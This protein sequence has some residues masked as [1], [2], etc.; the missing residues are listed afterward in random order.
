[1][2]IA[3]NTWYHGI[4]I[5]NNVLY[6]YVTYWKLTEQN[7]VEWYVTVNQKCYLLS[8]ICVRQAIKLVALSCLETQSMLSI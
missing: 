8:T 6:K 3:L 4:K 5:Y 2:Y 1:M 7:F